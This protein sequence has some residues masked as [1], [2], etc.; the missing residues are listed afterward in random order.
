M[1]KPYSTCINSIY[2]TLT[3]CS[4]SNVMITED[5]LNIRTNEIQASITKT[6]NLLSKRID[7]LENKVDSLQAD[8]TEIKDMLKKIVV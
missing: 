4:M 2:L 8:V 5:M 3:Q 7:S 6:A 1:Y